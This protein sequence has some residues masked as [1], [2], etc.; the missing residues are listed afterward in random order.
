MS[1]E[2]SS[3]NSGSNG[4]C[5][6]IGNANEAVF[7]DAGIHCS[8]IEKRMERLCIPMQKIK[9]VFITHE[10]TDH[11][12]GVYRL[13]KK[14]GLP[15]YLTAGT[16]SRSFFDLRE[17]NTICISPNETVEIGNLKI[18]AFSKSHDAADPVSFSVEHQQT[19]ISIITDI[20]YACENVKT[21]FNGSHAVILEANYDDNLI[22]NSSYP[23]KLKNRIK[24][25]NGHLS[26]ADALDLFK[27]FRHNNLSH[28]LLGH[29]SKENNE[30]ETILNLFQP[31]CGSTVVEIAP[32]YRESE[33]FFVDTT[34]FSVLKS[35]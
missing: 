7:I 23:A 1:I 3:I 25:T 6:Y 13:S 24:S 17:T 2:Y 29:V 21:H 18:T 19:R 22:A 12:R 10:H 15:V 20:G 16:L 27:N 8:E 9:A 35:G 33:L 31:H 14:Y 4:N 34:S 32:R 11:I 28:L 30:A 26:N 5:Y